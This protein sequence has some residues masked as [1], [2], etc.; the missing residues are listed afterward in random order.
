M[1]VPPFRERP[2]WALLQQHCQAVRSRHLRRDFADDPK[3]G[4]RMVAGRFQ[5]IAELRNPRFIGDR[6]ARIGCAGGGLGRIVPPQ[7]VN[8]V[9]VFGSCVVRLEVL[10]AD[11]PGR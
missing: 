10:I 8:V 3:R 5:V 2:A 1:N 9:H 7:P 11:R 6:R 4:E